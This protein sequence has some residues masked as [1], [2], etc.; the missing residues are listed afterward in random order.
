MATQHSFNEKI[1]SIPGVYADVKSGVNAPPLN[2]E[3]GNTL[4]IDTGSG[5]QYGGGSGISGTEENGRDAVYTFND[6]RSFRNFI[7]GGLHWLLSFKLFSP[8]PGSRGVS[9]LTYVRAAATTPGRIRYSWN[10]GGDH[11]GTVEFQTLSEGVVSN[12]FESDC[13]RA[14]SQV[15]VNNPGATGDTISLLAGTIALGS[16]VSEGGTSSDAASLLSLDINSNTR[17]HGYSSYHDGTSD[18]FE[19]IAPY[20]DCEATL[21]PSSSH[22]GD[23]SATGSP[24]AGGSGG[25]NH[26]GGFACRM[27]EGNTQGK[28]AIEFRRGNYKGLDAQVST[29]RL[30]GE[31]YDN[32]PLGESGSSLL[33]KSPDFGTVQE[34]LSWC[35]VNREFGTFFKVSLG[36]VFGDGSLAP[37]DLSSSLGNRLASGGSESFGTE[38]LEK[39]LDSIKGMNFDFVLCD[40]WGTEAYSNENLLILSFIVT[41][42]E[43]KPDMYVGGGLGFSSFSQPGG[44]IAVS[45]SYNSQYVTLVHGGVGM[46]VPRGGGY[47]D[48]ESVYHAALALGRE[49]GLA[50]QVPLTF[51]RLSI[52]R[53]LHTLNKKEQETGLS[54]GLLMTIPGNT[55]FQILK[56]VNTL[57]KNS[58]PVNSD[59]STHSK[60]IRRIVRQLNKELTVNIQ[61][62]FLDQPNGPNLNTASI[63]SVI[64]YVNTYLKGKQSTNLND[65]LIVMSRNV[66]GERRNDGYYITYEVQLNTA[67]NFVF[68]TGFIVDP[69]NS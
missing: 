65:N 26:V 20:W 3:Y 37:S 30:S 57:Q 45:E 54:S 38:H 39:A 46:P 31:P 62:R 63:E 60:Q 53:T 23:A 42:A 1:V 24:F 5:A 22:S 11:G 21:S 16:Y 36:E 66:K 6:V 51:K 27:T 15:T 43:I 49:A 12:G 64:Q 8:S 68:A 7:G 47:K 13:T 25:T 55:G 69:D 18:K 4:V 14:R 32:I 33:A 44:S 19:L 2:L 10:G 17:T 28:F 52:G 40:K 58:D 9:S 56:G 34:L 59:G 50:P 61:S 29:G 41:E 35:S 48:Y 67:V